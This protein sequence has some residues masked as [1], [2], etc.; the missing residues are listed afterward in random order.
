[1]NFLEIFKTFSENE[2]DWYEERSAILEY[3]AGMNRLTAQRK[4]IELT[5]QHFRR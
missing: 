2:K 4:A 5:V 1:M 3:D